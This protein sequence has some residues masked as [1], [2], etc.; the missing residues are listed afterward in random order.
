M[1]LGDGGGLRQT[2]LRPIVGADNVARLLS[3]GLPHLRGEA[4]V[5]RREINGSLGLIIRL[6]GEINN[7]VAMR[8]DD[9]LIA[10]LYL[11]RNPEKLS[12]VERETVVSRI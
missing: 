5:E 3:A 10:A 8:I 2:V 12:R 7:V 11:I 4:S 6:G 1:L 9:G